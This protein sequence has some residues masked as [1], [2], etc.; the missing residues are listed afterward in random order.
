MLRKTT[1]QETRGELGSEHSGLRVRKEPARPP[2]ESSMDGHHG[3]SRHHRS[4]ILTFEHHSRVSSRTANNGQLDT[5]PLSF[6]LKC[7]RTDLSYFLCQSWAPYN[8]REPAHGGRSQEMWGETL[9]TALTHVV[10]FLLAGP[11][12]LRISLF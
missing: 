6:Q 3:S 1:R 4:L 12:Q 10:Y 8:D 2:S 9:R 11:L 5:V 7:I